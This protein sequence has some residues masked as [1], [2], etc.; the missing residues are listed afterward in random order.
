MRIVVVGAGI[1]GA[2]VA[3][4]LAGSNAEVHLIDRA[5]DGKATSA[6]AGIVCTW[7]SKIDDPDLYSFYAEAGRYYTPLV[8]A[9]AAA[10]E[11]DLGYRKVG[12]LVLARDSAE[13]RDIERRLFPRAEADLEAGEIR[14][15]SGAEA[16]ALFPPMRDDLTAYFVPG[17]ARVEARKIAAAMVRAAITKGVRFTEG[18]AEFTLRNGKGAVALDGQDLAA[19]LVVLTTGSWANQMLGQAGKISVEPQKGQIVHVQVAADTSEWPVLLP[20]GPYYM[21][22]FENNRV[23]IGATRETG[24][25]FDYRVTASGQKEILDFGLDLAPGLRDATLVE[26]RVGFRPAAV[27]GKPMFG[28]LPGMEGVLIGNGLGASG[29]TMG[30]FGGKL[31]AQLALGQKPD[32]DLSHF[33]VV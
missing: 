14:R 2:S 17:G 9:L 28:A 30:P 26:T 13:C 4:H 1:L 33:P 10:G 22:A 31:L 25:G 18:N 23:V 32:H 29:L 5:H 6:G 15:M 24:S 3:Y 19:D 16:K 21:L 27:A 8:A 7:P 11:T 20:E 12:A